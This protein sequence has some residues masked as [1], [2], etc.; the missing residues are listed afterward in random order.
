MNNK[1]KALILIGS[2]ALFS[3]VFRLVYLARVDL[4]NKNLCVKQYKKYFKNQY[5]YNDDEMK[6]LLQADAYKECK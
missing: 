6:G 2:V 4:N 1:I 5:Q 3:E